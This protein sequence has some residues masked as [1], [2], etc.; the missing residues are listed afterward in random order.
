MAELTTINIL[1]YDTIDDFIEYAYSL[2]QLRFRNSDRRIMFRNR[3]IFIDYTELHEEKSIT[4]WHIASLEGDD[5]YNKYTQYPCQNTFSIG[6]CDSMCNINGDKCFYIKNTPRIVCIYRASFIN[7][8]YEII[9]LCNEKSEFIQTIDS[10]RNVR[11]KRTKRIILRY[12]DKYYDYV[13]IFEPKYTEGK[14]DIKNY[15]LITAYP[16]FNKDDIFELDKKWKE[17]SSKK[18]SHL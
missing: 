16:V 1:E 6:N 2:F 3:P 17:Q 9:K 14:K 10:V 4:F 11:G 8:V 13:I 5:S 12:K 15:K 18:E 7:F